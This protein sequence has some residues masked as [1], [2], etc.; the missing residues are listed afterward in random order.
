MRPPKLIQAVITLATSAILFAACGSDGDGAASNSGGSGGSQSD[1]G[2]N[3]GTAG[4]GANGGDAAADTTFPIDG[5]NGA[6][7]A[8]AAADV[9]CGATG[10]A[11]EAKLPNMLILFDRS[12]S[13]R[14]KV[15][16]S[17]AF[18]TGPDDPET[19]WYVAREAVD[20]LATEYQT[21]VRFGMMVF[22]EPREDC[23]EYPA[24]NVQ[25]DVLTAGA[26]LDVLTEP[27]VQPFTL[28]T[29]PGSSIPGEQPH[30]TPT[31]EALDTVINSGVLQDP[32]RNNY[33]LLITDGGATC[34][35][36]A[37]SLGSQAT[38]LLASGVQ[39]AVVGFGDVETG[40][41]ADM[42]NAMAQ[43]GGLPRPAGPP[44]FWL[45]V[46]PTELAD[47]LDAIVAESVSCTFEL[48]GTPPEPD[49]LYVF[50][51]GTELVRDA[52]DGW[53]Y[54]EATNTVTFQGG[55]CDAI[56]SGDSHSI[57]VVYGCPEDVCT[58][59]DEVCDGID[60]DCDGIV[61]EGCVN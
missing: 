32:E 52:A 57:N 12:C 13:M 41:A 59:T 21:R 58:P 49:K 24:I 19:R 8:D 55:A 5:G 51:D 27:D 18:G 39:T 60:N 43:A 10:L 25:P 9:S 34:D 22:P 33:L 36:T 28:C 7:D 11:V 1:A 26:I 15:F 17:S 50:V 2:G 42:L 23:G 3:G 47:A 61:D 40:T 29:Q 6:P 48:Q 56:R 31:A 16:D 30:V 4:T 14:R 45:A 54:D 38:T 44:F 46:N 20:T 37:A 53:V 35:A